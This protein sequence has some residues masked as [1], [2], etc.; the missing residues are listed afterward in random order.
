MTGDLMNDANLFTQV[1][2]GGLLLGW[3]PSGRSINAQG[4]Y[5]ERNGQPKNSDL[6]L[7]SPKRL[8][9]AGLTLLLA[10][11][12][13]MTKLAKTLESL[14]TS[15]AWKGNLERGMSTL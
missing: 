13:R 11:F 8:R 2:D 15:G 5:Y 3:A 14:V 9:K 12:L 4:V 6:F 10:P 7:Q 1:Q